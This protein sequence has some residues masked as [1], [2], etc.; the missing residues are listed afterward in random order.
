MEESAGA[1]LGKHADYRFHDEACQACCNVAL[2]TF[3]DV[4]LATYEVL[5]K[6]L[7]HIDRFFESSRERRAG[8]TAARSSG[9]HVEDA[10]C[11]M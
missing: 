11:D 2:R 5:M 9:G 10:S 8:L 6:E 3:R 1:F 4:V 7:V